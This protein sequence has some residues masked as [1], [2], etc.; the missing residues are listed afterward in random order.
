MNPIGSKVSQRWEN[1]K[2]TVFVVSHLGTIIRE[3]EYRAKTSAN[4][5]NMNNRL[6]MIP[7]KW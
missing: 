6:H 3:P 7:S 2:T 5:I 4:Y 1:A